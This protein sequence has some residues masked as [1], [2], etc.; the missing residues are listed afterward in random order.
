MEQRN[1]YFTNADHANLIFFQFPKLLMYGEK[2]REMSSDSKLLYML[3]LDLIKLSMKHGWKDKE[4]RYYIKMSLET[5]QERLNCAKQKAQKLKK[6]LE[7]YGLLEEERVGFGKSN[8]LFVLQLEYTDEDIIKANMDHEDIPND[9]NK[10]SSE[11]PEDVP[12]TPEN[13]SEKDGALEPQ[14]K[15]ENHPPE[16]RKSSPIKNNNIN[17]N[18]KDLNKEIDDDKRTSPEGKDSPVHSDEYVN[19]I[20][21][22]FYEEVKLDLSDRSFKS[23]VRKVMDKY[24]QGK[25]KGSFRDYLATSLINKIEELELRRIKDVA[26]QKL[27]EKTSEEIA[28]KLE[29]LKVS[30]NIPFYNWLEED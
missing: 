2:Y 16:V 15:D 5:I 18:Y 13:S 19:L 7:T 27:R 6:E 4:G 10:T 1:R 29:S 22:N 8:R 25:I 20:I 23:V 30:D 28:D 17:N 21:S 14:Q 24:R 9:E 12:N 11:V 3:A 26:K